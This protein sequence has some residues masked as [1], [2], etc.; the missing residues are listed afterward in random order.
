MYVTE[1]LI[2]GEESLGDFQEN[3][4][5]KMKLEAQQT[6]A[7]AYYSQALNSINNKQ[8]KGE[9]FHVNSCFNKHLFIDNVLIIFIFHV[10][11][12]SDDREEAF[13][14]YKSDKNLTIQ[15]RWLLAKAY[16]L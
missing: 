12:T 13:M 5:I 2:N 9:D 6:M 16:F 3:D 8:F 11:E 10:T 1:P 15:I 4:D 7:L 14:C